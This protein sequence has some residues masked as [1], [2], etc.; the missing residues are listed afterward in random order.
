MKNRRIIPLLVYLVALILILSWLTDGFGLGRDDLSYTQIVRLFEEEQVKSFI[1]QGNLIELQL[2]GTYN[3]DKELLCHLGDPA[4]FREQMQP[5]LDAQRES[6]ILESYNFLAQEQFTPMD[7]VLPLLIVGGILLL[8]WFLL[9][10]RAT[11]GGNNMSNFG[12]ARTVQG[13]PD[14]RKVTFQ[15]VAGADEEKLELQ[16]VVDFLRNPEKFHQMGARIPH[17]ILLVGPPGTGKTLLAKAVAGEA[18][19]RFQIGRAHV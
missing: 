19:V 12:K 1:I 15:D 2:H 7:L 10:S 18:G 8:L 4:Y 9:M 3:G 14:G 11:A 13:I 17:G 6:G 5:L 16:E